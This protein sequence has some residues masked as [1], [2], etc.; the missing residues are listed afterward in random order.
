MCQVRLAPMPAHSERPATKKRD[1]A[2]SASDVSEYAALSGI[3]RTSA[4][5][6]ELN[7]RGFYS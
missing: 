2:G 4:A 1:P 7:L 6:T 3:S 5:L